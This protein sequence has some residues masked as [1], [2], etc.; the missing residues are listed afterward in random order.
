[1]MIVREISQ[2]KFFAC[3]KYISRIYMRINSVNDASTCASRYPFKYAE[4]YIQNQCH[5][6]F[7]QFVLC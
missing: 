7:S 2:V 6:T 1:M 3:T 4:L 5:T